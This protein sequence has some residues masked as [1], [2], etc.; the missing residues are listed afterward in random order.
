MTVARWSAHGAVVFALLFLPLFLGSYTIH[1]ANLALIY[2]MLTV[3]LSIA[4][5]YAGQVNLAQAACFGIGS[6]AVAVLTV[7]TGMHYWVAF[8]FGI[9][10]GGLL[11]LLV[12]IPSLRVQSHYLGI[13]TLGLAI[14][15]TAILTNWSYT[16]QAIGL[17]GVPGPTFP[18]TNLGDEHNLYYVLLAAVVLLFALALLMTSTGLGRR[19]KALRDDYVAAAHSGV[20]VPIYRMV[21]FMLA[22]AYAGVAGAFYAGISHYVSPDTYSLAIMFLLLAMVIM[23]GRD[24]IYGAVLGAI[25]LIWVRQK[26]ETLQ[27]YQQIGYGVLIV[28]TVVFAPS[29]LAGLFTSA[30]NRG[31]ALV[32]PN[33]LPAS[34]EYLEDEETQG[35]A[36]DPG[37]PSEVATTRATALA[38]EEKMPVLEIS[39]IVKRFRGLT[40]L[41]G[42]SIDVYAGTIHGIVGP[43]GSGKTTL[44]NIVTGVYGPSSGNVN[45]FGR[46]VSG[47][48][49]YRV[50]RRGIAR[51]FQGVRLFRSLTVRENVMVALD[52]S[53]PRSN[54]RYL[55]APWLV[56]LR[57]RDLR[58]R[59]DLHLKHYRLSSVA[60][61]LGTHLPY[62]QQRLVEIARAMA[63]KPD[64]LLLDEPAA[65]LN[66]TEM[67]ELATL[68][69]SIRDAD[70]TVVLIEHNMSL[71]MS[72]CD[73]VTVLANGAVIA[74]GLPEQIARDPQVIEAYLGAEHKS[75]E[76]GVGSLA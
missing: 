5:G 73:R 56:V 6:Y 43:N 29:G 12:S 58:R 74:D 8:P 61:F 25:L 39:G 60:D 20:E 44:F 50:A 75:E 41:D 51:T 72:L 59:A 37:T 19:F 18:G 64:I 53:R 27:Q 55:Y 4:L 9:V 32:R 38:T 35:L 54:W 63:G 33:R 76:E 11:G 10:A 40:A 2:V 68:V 34:M 46:R 3:G 36:V 15:F 52:E 31:L 26:F 47:E 65:G 42:V 69:R 23:G 30:W 71:V 62:G 57:E 17:P 16:G 1:I 28:A 70:T 67:Q 22:G 66:S 49:A 7:R 14:S 45:L 21:A 24:N 48:R 13:V